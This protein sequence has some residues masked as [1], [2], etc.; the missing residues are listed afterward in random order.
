MTPQPDLVLLHPPTVYDFREHSI[1]YGP[2]SDLVPSTPI[3][4][5]YPIGF[6]TIA[7]HLAKC[8][9][10]VRIMNLGGRMLGSRKFNVPRMISKIRPA[11][12]GIDLHWLPH[13][14]GAIEIARLCKKF[15]PETPIIMGGYSA[16]YFAREVMDYDCVD[17]ILRGDTTERALEQLLDYIT[18]RVNGGDPDGIS[19]LVRINKDGSIRENDL[20]APPATL[21][22]YTVDY[23]EITRSVIR[24]RDI[25]SILPSRD[26]LNYPITLTMSCKGCTENCVICGGSKW[27]LN[28]MFGRK[29]PSYRSP[30]GLLDD[31]I[32]ISEFSRGP[33]F[34]LGDLL[35]SGEAYAEEFLEKAAARRIE[36]PVIIELFNPAP[37][38]FFKKVDRAFK[39]YTAEIS[40][41]THDDEL[42]NR[43]GKRYGTV[44]M[45]KSIAAALSNGCRRFDIFFMIG[46]PGQDAQSCLDT[47][48]YGSKLLSDFGTRVNLFTS[49][50]APFLDPG[51]IAF[52]NPDRFGYKIRFRTLEEY[53]TALL[54]PLWKDTLSYESETLSRDEIADVTYE[55]GLLLNRM[56]SDSGTIDKQICKQTELR[57]LEARKIMKKIEKLQ[58]S[59]GNSGSLEA[60]RRDISGLSLST[61]CE[62]SEMKIPKMAR[63][64][65][66]R[67][68]LKMIGR[69]GRRKIS[70]KKRVL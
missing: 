14:N 35:S 56:K 65:R 50:L 9:Y 17:Y 60:F 47:V 61:V 20:S 45:E 19:G 46:I 52:E 27:S 42:R 15:H 12:F 39:W 31:F 33:I 44:E 25:E 40:P 41:E 48:K 69:S 58:A 36:N 43:A 1:L 24:Y 54:A 8:G 30:D 16:S 18:G 53:R 2:V 3:F 63:N 64:F 55:S 10:E 38:W 66:I 26:W 6:S 7:G 21:D 59:G 68:F 32:R 49:P 70:R 28:R 67:Y 34:L 4:E 37:Q 13:A 51:S 22:E 23:D 5:M 11:A 62:K 29:K 57:I